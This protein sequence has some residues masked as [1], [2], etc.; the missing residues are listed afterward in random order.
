MCPIN[1]A[2]FSGGSSGANFS[3]AGPKARPTGSASR[4]AGIPLSSG[5]T[6]H[7]ALPDQ[8]TLPLHLVLLPGLGPTEVTQAE[9][10]S[11]IPLSLV[12]SRVSASS[13][14]AGEPKGQYI[15]LGWSKIMWGLSLFLVIK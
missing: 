15:C 7:S 3:L 14:E 4:G 10:P 1:T 5:R 12:A 13:S 6:G 8:P 9:V 2:L 11:L